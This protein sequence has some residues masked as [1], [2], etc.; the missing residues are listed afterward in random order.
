M[1]SSAYRI[2]EDKPLKNDPDDFISYSIV[3]RTGS[4]WHVLGHSGNLL[5]AKLY[6]LW[7]VWKELGK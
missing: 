3:R 5:V 6:V 4:T 1:K 2:L 7:Q